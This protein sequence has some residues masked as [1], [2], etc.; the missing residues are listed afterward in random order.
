MKRLINISS[1]TRKA[2]T[3]LLLLYFILTPFLFA[4][5]QERCSASCPMMLEKEACDMHS[6]NMEM[7]ENQMDVFHLNNPS[8]TSGE[9]FS[10]MKCLIEKY[11]NSTKSFVVSEKNQQI[12][13][14]S[15]VSLIGQFSENRSYTIS[16][17]PET[18]VN[19]ESPP[20]YISVQSFLI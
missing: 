20:L 14:L 6:G 5:P 9:E 18:F 10:S 16:V 12:S 15:V 2:T 7:G 3:Y 17:K 1:E 13:E 8:T 4:I 11:F 19:F